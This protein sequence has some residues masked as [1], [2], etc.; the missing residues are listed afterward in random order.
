MSAYLTLEAEE[1]VLVRQLDIE[2]DDDGNVM[3]W[4]LE[5]IPG[6]SCGF[7]NKIAIP[8]HLAETVAARIMRAVREARNAS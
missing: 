7:S 2:A 1:G 8:L 5:E 4:E 6:V 3:L